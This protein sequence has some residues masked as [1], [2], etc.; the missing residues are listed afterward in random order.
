MQLVGAYSVEAKANW[1]MTW[2]SF[3]EGYHVAF[4]HKRSAVRAYADK[5]NP[6]MHARRFVYSSCIG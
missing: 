3:Q 1:K 6:V 4:L 2:N 5:K